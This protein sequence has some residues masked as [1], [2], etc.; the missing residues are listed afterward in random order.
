MN[1]FEFVIALVVIIMAGRI[2]QSRLAARGG[3][4]GGGADP[5]LSRARDEIRALSER[6][7][8]LERVVTDNHG[9]HELDRE[10]ER[11]RDR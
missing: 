10:I 9:S 2:I 1:P 3:E 7:R 8:V 4:R 11:L 6:V 5:E